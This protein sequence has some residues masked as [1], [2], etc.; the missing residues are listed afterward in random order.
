MMEVQTFTTSAWLV[1]L[2]CAVAATLIGAVVDGF[3]RLAGGPP[4]PRVR[5]PGQSEADYLLGAKMQA[6]CTTKGM[7]GLRIR[8]E[9]SAAA[10]DEWSVDE[11][12]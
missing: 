2:V 9:G 6:R 4:Q 7:P 1:A 5:Q 11:V 3:K 10:A 8:V 12:R